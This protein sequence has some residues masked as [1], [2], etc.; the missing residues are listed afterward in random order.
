MS[1]LSELTHNRHDS[2]QQA[3]RNG[4][5]NIVNHHAEKQKERMNAI[6][7]KNRLTQILYQAAAAIEHYSNI[8][9]LLVS[10]SLS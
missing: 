10:L 3:T 8:E 9:S 2:R 4:G 5:T 1:A 7:H 6:K